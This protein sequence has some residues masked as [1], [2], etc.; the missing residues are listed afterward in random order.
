MTLEA[1]FYVE[2]ESRRSKHGSIMIRVD[3]REDED[4]VTYEMMRN[5]TRTFTS[6]L[7]RVELPYRVTDFNLS[8]QDTYL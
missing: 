7:M 2:Y 3:L 4:G 5:M 8:L 6:N 1:R